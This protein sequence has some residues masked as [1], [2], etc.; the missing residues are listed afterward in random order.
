MVETDYEKKD[1]TA[2]PKSKSGA[3]DG[4]EIFEKRGVWCAR[5]PSGALSKHDSKEDALEHAN[6]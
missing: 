1:I 4:W 3:P 2:S 5:H 6:G